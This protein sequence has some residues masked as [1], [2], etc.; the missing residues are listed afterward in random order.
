[1]NNKKNFLEFIASKPGNGTPEHW[2][3]VIPL[4]FEENNWVHE[5]DCTRVSCT[6]NL[7]L[8]EQYLKEYREY[9]FKYAQYE[10]L[11]LEQIQDIVIKTR[12][13]WEGVEKYSEAYQSGYQEA[14]D[15]FM[16]LLE[17]HMRGE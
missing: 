6:C 14:L 1:M 3:R 11:S 15:D 10:K 2:K 7:C 9:I 12:G 17:D 13:D 16:L 8:I 4:M 5:G